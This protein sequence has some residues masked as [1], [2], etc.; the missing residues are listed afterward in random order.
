M[1]LTKIGFAA[2]TALCLSM[3]SAYA[4]SNEAYLTQTKDNHSA[5]IDQS[6]GSG[7]KAGRSD[8][9]ILQFGRNTTLGNTLTID[10]D[11]SN[12]AVGTGQVA[13]GENT[14]F[15]Q[16]NQ[17]GPG[18][19]ATISQDSSGTAAALGNS[20]VKVYQRSETASASGSLLVATQTGDENEITSV[21]QRRNGST[22][23]STAG[24]LGHTAT[25]SQTGNDNLIALV[26]QS[27]ANQSA[28]L[29]ITGNSNGR[30]T[31]SG[32][33]AV[34][35]A[36]SSAVQSG[37]SN[38]LNYMVSDGDNNQFG[39]LQAGNGNSA[40]GLTILGDR[41][42]LGIYQSGNTN[43]VSLAAVT[44]DDNVI[45][46]TQNGVGNTA[47]ASILNG[48]SNNEFGIMQNGVTN[49]ASLSIDGDDNGLSSSTGLFGVAATVGGLDGMIS[50]W[51]TS[52]EATLTVVGNGNAFA[53]GQGAALGDGNGNLITG[54]VSG[55]NNAAA[56]SQLSNGNT[57]VFT[58]T[59]NGNAA[60]ISQG[61]TSPTT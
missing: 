15:Y 14:G 36:D 61:V 48:G 32:L 30:G 31:L 11:G 21:S 47:S 13:A 59:G 26:N 49:V 34:G 19:T 3:A 18:S 40:E 24:R 25:L 22:D 33:A 23:G 56:V 52:N 7:N 6:D 16:L 41:N 53:L 9:A 42:E 55:N 17:S 8:G 58:Q 2:S 10:Q 44:G 28:V 29:S 38:R 46:L 45:G 51:G 12:N 1:K 35:A 39:F 27:G 20:I 57:A 43:T 5:L 50:Q 60:G 4:D 37:S 54:V